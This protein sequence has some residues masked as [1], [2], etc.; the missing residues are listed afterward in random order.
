MSGDSNP[1]P[2]PAPSP[3]PVRLIGRVLFACLAVSAFYASASVASVCRVTP[4]GAAAGSGTW[5]APMDMQ[6]A[7][8][9]PV[10]DEIWAKAGTYKPT[11]GTD[12]NISF[13]LDR[14]VAVYGGFAGSE[15]ARDQRNP[16]THVSILSGD[17]GTANDNS[18][19]S[20]H[21]VYIVGDAATKIDND[22]VLNGFTITDGNASG[23]ELPLFNGG[24]LLCTG[25]QAGGQ[26]SPTLR[27]LIF[28]NNRANFAG[29]GMEISCWV[30][31]VASP[32]LSDI[33]FSNNHAG[34]SGGALH[35]GS[36]CEEIFSLER[37]TFE[38]NDA[39]NGG[40]LHAGYTSGVEMRDIVFLN[41]TANQDGGATHITSLDSVVLERVR[42]EGN[43]AKKQGGAMYN[44]STIAGRTSTISLV[45]VIFNNNSVLNAASNGQGGAINN[46][47]FGGSMNLLMNR[48]TLSNNQANFAG[49]IRNIDSYVSGNLTATLSNV[50]FS[51]NSATTSSRDMTSSANYHSVDINLRNVTLDS[52]SG[53]GYYS[54]VN[55]SQGNGTVNLELSN[56]IL[57]DSNR[58]LP[59]ANSGPATTIHI[60]HSIVVRSKGSGINWVSSLG[61]DGGGNIDADPLLGALANNGGYTQTMLPAAGSPAI[62]AG[63]A[64]TCTAA[65]VSGLDQHGGTR[66][67]GP[68]CDIGAVEVGAVSNS[69]GIFADGFE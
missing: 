18:D 67:H 42:F 35:R 25:K 5:A 45:D 68:Q 57:W 61:T 60:D 36:E 3:N 43:S 69:G 64:T 66:P 7:L 10:C 15:T 6:T 2:N 50:T 48:V 24:G 9:N 54:L 11:T 12:R 39:N 19:N 58:S 30:D 59:I 49:A 52:S 63:L 38:G 47:A 56:V 22:T 21:V 4:T 41:N 34:S 17:I 8:G 26:C 32:V 1:C 33:H 28:T 53:N 13:T 46:E 55:T 16:A 62:D 27:Q 44:Q 37:V 20:Y 31:A 40:A 29:G 65:P 51:N 23:T 14:T